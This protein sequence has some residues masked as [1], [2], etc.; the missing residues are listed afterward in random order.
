MS[1]NGHGGREA[2]ICEPL[3]TPVGRFGGMF[4]DLDAAKLASTV[5]GELVARAGLR[6]EDVD[7]VVLGQCS[8]NDP[9]HRPVPA[10][11]CPHWPEPVRL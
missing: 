10:H 5:I 11:D 6:G 2:V 9:P 7:D 4:R 3:R 1:T 8:P